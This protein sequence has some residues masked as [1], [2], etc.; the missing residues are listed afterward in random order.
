MTKRIGLEIG[1]SKTKIV[2]GKYSNKDYK[3]IGYEVIDTVE[4]VYTIDEE[5]DIMKMEL[6]IKAALDKLGIKSG[7]LNI[8][9]NNEKVIIRTRELP[10]VSPKDMKAVVSFEAENFL[11]YDINE[12]YVDYKILNEIDEEDKESDSNDKET[13]FNV[14][15][16][17]APKFIVDQ[18]V[19]LANALKLTLKV[20]TV[21]TESINKY[22]EK[23]I[24]E[25]GKNML[26]VDIGSTYTNMIMYQGHHYF[27]NIKADIGINE[28]KERLIETYG[29][30]E[31][32]VE[33]QLF[34]IKDTTVDEDSS[35][36][37]DKLDVLK[38]TLASKDKSQGSESKLHLLQKKL[39]KV[40]KA[41]KSFSIPETDIISQRNDE[42]L[43]II[44]EITRMIEF[45]KSREYGT[46]VDAVYLFGG[47]AYL[48]G[49]K[50][51][52]INET[53]IKV[54]VLPDVEEGKTLY[55]DDFQA[56]LSTVGSCIG[57]RS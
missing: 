17:A 24:L 57:G 21:Y 45:F 54:D 34:S 1:T 3:V 49:F 2:V 5:T 36:P 13:L 50:D 53:G 30:N 35:M 8:T 19:E 52:L 37:L 15:I 42:Y 12:F 14:M 26:F 32:D 28:M 48:D 25:A 38:S 9:M 29:Y 39:D 27:A 10:R 51:L 47:G 44:K 23:N 33:Y 55:R 6:P 56:L 4:G 43:S 31:R 22:L 7:N 16:I 18:Y 41:K 46:F 40:R 11:P 20:T